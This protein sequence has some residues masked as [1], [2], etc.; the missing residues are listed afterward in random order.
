MT[1]Y[2]KFRG[3]DNPAI[4]GTEL[5]YGEGVFTISKVYTTD[6][7]NTCTESTHR[8]LP[9]A[10]FI[11]DIGTHLLEELV[12]FDEVFPDSSSEDSNDQS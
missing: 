9:E 4:E 5:Y 3:F 2:F 10:I 8:P 12:F 7:V 1:R 6:E 11:D